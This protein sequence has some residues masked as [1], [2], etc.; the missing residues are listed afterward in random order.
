MIYTPFLLT[1]WWHSIYLVKPRDILT[2]TFPSRNVF[3]VCILPRGMCVCHSSRVLS[4]M[5]LLLSNMQVCVLSSMWFAVCA[6]FCFL[7]SCHWHCSLAPALP[8]FELVYRVGSPLR[9]L[10]VCGMPIAT[11]TFIH[12]PSGLS[13]RSTRIGTLLVRS[14]GIETKR[15]LIEDLPGTVYSNSA[16]LVIC[17]FSCG[18]RRFVT[19]FA[20]ACDESCIEPVQFALH[21]VG[22]Y[23]LYLFKYYFHFYPK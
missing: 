2:F 9:I 16:D 22:P 14:A 8:S 18:F 12:T 19:V 13:V 7:F 3:P 10:D 20:K 21:T 17:R 4:S 6:F 23:F 5:C 1:S 15:R 11:R